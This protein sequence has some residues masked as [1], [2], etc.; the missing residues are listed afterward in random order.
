MN[1]VAIREALAATIE[2]EIGIKCHPAPPAKVNLP[3][4]IVYPGA[5][6]SGSRYWTQDTPCSG[7]F[8]YE[9]FILVRADLGPAA[10]DRLDGYLEQFPGA[11]E[12]AGGDLGQVHTPQFY[13]FASQKCLATSVE[14]SLQAEF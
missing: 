5:T 6:G 14:L 11:V 4:A 9:V 8:F 12:S 10:F 13:E 3:A 1:L 7:T 2:A